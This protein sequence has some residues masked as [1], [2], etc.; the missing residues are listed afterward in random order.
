MMGRSFPPPAHSI[1]AGHGFAPSATSAV[2]APPEVMGRPIEPQ[3][4][5]AGTCGLYSLGHA[6][7][8][9]YGLDGPNTEFVIQLLLEAAGIVGPGVTGQG[10]ITSFHNAMAII[11]EYNQGRTPYKVNLDA[12][13]IDSSMNTAAD[14]RT[15]LDT[16]GTN[17]PELVG[18][19]L[20]VDAHL[21]SAP[22]E[23]AF[24][25]LFPDDPIATPPALSPLAIPA[26]ADRAGATVDT[27]NNTIVMDH[28]AN[29]MPSPSSSYAHW[30]TISGIDSRYVT[31]I[32]ANF[33]EYE[34]KV[35]VAEAHRLTTEL[36]SPTRGDYLQEVYDGSVDQSTQGVRP[37][38]P[39]DFVDSMLDQHGENED[40]N[41]MNP[42]TSPGRVPLEMERRLATTDTASQVDLQGLSLRV[43]RQ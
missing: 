26:Q 43:T 19:T 16:T 7:A 38:R 32:D 30:V 4:Q 42:G 39:A 12:K 10:E 28:F 34:L 11:N 14:W 8:W 31:L 6:I 40:W 9:V 20:A 13:P 36:T 5:Q 33:P 22:I 25:A 21:Y 18:A 23:E 35:P 27:T 41:S 29:G 15:A 37:G 17:S 3:A 24:D 2:A 1:S